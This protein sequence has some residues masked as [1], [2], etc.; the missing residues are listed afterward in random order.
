MT[1][2]IIEFEDHGQDFL[3]WEI[4]RGVVTCSRPFQSWCWN[5]LKV[6]MRKAQVGRPLPVVL[7]SGEATQI[8]YPVRKIT[9]DS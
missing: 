7:Q 5:G 4:E 9:K 8:K 3:S 1:K 6:D 2:H